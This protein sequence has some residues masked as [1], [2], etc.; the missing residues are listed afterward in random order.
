MVIY[1]NLSFHISVL[2]CN[3][4]KAS[5]VRLLELGTIFLWDCDQ[6]AGCGSLGLASLADFGS[7]LNVNVGNTFVFT[8][9][10]EV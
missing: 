10:R 8:E 6:D 2:G 4:F 9:D 3:E 7:A 1:I 5:I